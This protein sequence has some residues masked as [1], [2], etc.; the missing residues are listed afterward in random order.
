MSDVVVRLLK[1]RVRGVSL[2]EALALLCLAVLVICVYMFKA[3]ASQEG[4]RISDLDRQ[5]NAELRDVRHLREEVSRLEQPA[6]IEQ[7][8]SQYLAMKPVGQSQDMS[9]SELAAKLHGSA[10]AV[11]A[12]AAGAAQP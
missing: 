7:M 5:I 3:G 4:A 9:P 2:V 8:S 12:K 11:P 10:A 1:A 6:R